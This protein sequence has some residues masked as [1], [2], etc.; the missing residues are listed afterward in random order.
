MHN[1]THEEVVLSSADAK[2]LKEPDCGI[3][4]NNWSETSAQ[5]KVPGSPF[6]FML[7]C[8]FKT[9]CIEGM[10]EAGEPM[11]KKTRIRAKGK[12]AVAIASSFSEASFAPAPP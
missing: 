9:Q 8:L 3:V 1:Y 7:S 4:V 5:L 10:S 11:C 12:A 2:R 6:K